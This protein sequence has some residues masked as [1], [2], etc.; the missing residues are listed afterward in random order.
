ME[1]KKLWYK[2]APLKRIEDYEDGN[3]FLFVKS[4]Y[5]L[6]KLAERFMARAPTGTDFKS[7]NSLLIKYLNHTYSYWLGK[8]GQLITQ[9]KNHTVWRIYSLKNKI[10]TKNR[11]VS[12]EP[13][14]TASLPTTAGD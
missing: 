13:A 1:N 6:N 8:I 4:Y 12:I 11:K 10:S 9:Y 7:I 3:F 2:N 5:Q 14:I